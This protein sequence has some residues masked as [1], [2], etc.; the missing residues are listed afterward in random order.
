MIV[1]I[2]GPSASGKSTIGRRLAR[3]LQLPLVDS[4]LMY[5]AVTVLAGDEGID[6]GDE[7]ALAALARRTPIEVNTDPDAGSGAWLVR[8][9]GTDITARVYDAALAPALVRVS[10]APGVRDEMVAQQR[11]LGG[12][13]VVMVGRDIG[14][15]VF[16]AADLK[17]FVTA[18]EAER[19]RRRARQKGET[20]AGLSKG[21][22]EDRDAADT[23][24]SLAPLRA[25]SDAH[26]IDTDGR[27]P[28]D[29]F[30]EILRLIGPP[31]GGA[32]GA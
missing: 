25:A 1:A 14:T 5:R 2:D 17:L 27:S 31:G 9:G 6:P 12:G 23:G 4:G 21:E 13:G 15:V 10:Q 24:R 18:T 8:A 3:R 7:D 29:V 16:P 19:R 32:A 30:D 28:D 22:I 11:R 20:E 26:T